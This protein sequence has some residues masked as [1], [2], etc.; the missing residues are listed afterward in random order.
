ML[1]LITR[2][3]MR[4]KDGQ[5]NTGEW[6]KACL[7][8]ASRCETRL[9]FLCILYIAQSIG[10]LFAKQDITYYLPRKANLKPS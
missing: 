5:Y 8:I 4:S 3:I 7:M 6:L 9:W 1:A 2:E 10:H